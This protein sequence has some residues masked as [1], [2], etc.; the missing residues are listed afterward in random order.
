MI[1][2][3]LTALILFLL[4][5]LAYQDWKEKK[6]S[7][8]PLA[9]L[10]LLTGIYFVLELDMYTVKDYMAIGFVLVIFAVL[11]I[12][13][14]MGLGDI[15]VISIIV[16]NPFI[17]IIAL[18]LA[19]IFIVV[20]AVMKYVKT[21]SFTTHKFPLIPIFLFTLIITGVF[22][23]DHIS[24]PHI[25]HITEE[26]V[27]DLILNISKYDDCS[28]LIDVRYDYIQGNTNM[29]FSISEK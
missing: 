8:V 17:G 11:I 27:E 23:F 20:S 18:F 19:S 26:T 2:T 21:K 29:N 25:C 1:M 13:R 15:A 14:N 28:V 10:L 3:I 22:M 5:F 12:T 7:V 9:I 16:L 24:K 6:V 4:A